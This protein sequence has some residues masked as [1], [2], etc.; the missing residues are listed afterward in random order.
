MPQ[1]QQKML[2]ILD[3]TAHSYFHDNIF[4]VN[5]PFGSQ[6][7]PCKKQYAVGLTNDVMVASFSQMTH[8][9]SHCRISESNG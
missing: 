3:Q 8:F 7:L 1:W 5:E 4:E 2:E 9:S 6:M